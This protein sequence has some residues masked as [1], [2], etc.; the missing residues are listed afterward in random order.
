LAPSRFSNWHFWHFING[1]PNSYD[2]VMK[3]AAWGKKTPRRLDSL[4]EV[5]LSSFIAPFLMGST[6]IQKVVIEGYFCIYELT[7]SNFIM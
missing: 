6:N 1:T 2:L 5:G 3:R 7:Y 4:L